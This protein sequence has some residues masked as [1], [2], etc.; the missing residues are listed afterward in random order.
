MVATSEIVEDDAA[1]DAPPTDGSVAETAAEPAAAETAETAAAVESAAPPAQPAATPDPA[2]PDPATPDLAAP[3]PGAD[4]TNP[5]LARPFVQVGLFGVK[6]NAE[7]LGQRLRADGL[8]V[9]LVERSVGGR[10]F[11]RVLVGPARTAA[12]L[13]ALVRDIR[14]RGF[15]DAIPVAG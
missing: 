9:R 12:E 14:N 4:A 11:T 3:A 6:S 1:F 2:T 15:T 8:S 13:Q 5:P 7:A 10:L